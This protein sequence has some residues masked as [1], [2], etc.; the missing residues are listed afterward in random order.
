VVVVQGPQVLADLL[1]P[2][3]QLLFDV[4]VGGH[5][6]VGWWFRVWLR[7]YTGCRIRRGQRT[8]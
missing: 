5:G 8:R 2:L 6:L 1:G 7:G 4:G 3:E